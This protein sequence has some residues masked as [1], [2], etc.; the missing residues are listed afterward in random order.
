[1]WITFNNRIDINT[2]ILIDCRDMFGNENIA[3]TYKLAKS[4]NFTKGLVF[5]IDSL[6]FAIFFLKNLDEFKNSSALIKTKDTTYYLSDIEI[7]NSY[8]IKDIIV[9]DV[10]IDINIFKWISTDI[11]TI[12][13]GRGLIKFD[14]GYI[15]FE[16]K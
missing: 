1:M 2:T 12:Q 13:K 10:I 9:S 3:P 7:D 4:L 11:R 15:I 6:F 5:S 16:E 8:E 14:N